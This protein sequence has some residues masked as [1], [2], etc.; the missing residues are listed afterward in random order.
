VA[1]RKSVRLTEARRLE[2]LDLMT[3]IMGYTELL[4]REGS[5]AAEWEAHL[6]IVEESA[7]SLSRLLF[8]SVSTQ[9][10]KRASAR[11]QN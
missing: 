5:T 10:A 11:K 6:A 2:A 1:V 7:R 8:G 4:R 9:Q 3:A